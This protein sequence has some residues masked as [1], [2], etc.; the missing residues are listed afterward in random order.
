MLLQCRGLLL[1]IIINKLEPTLPRKVFP[2]CLLGGSCSQPYSLRPRCQLRRPTVMGLIK[3]DFSIFLIYFSFIITKMGMW[4]SEH[5]K[6]RL[7]LCLS[8]SVTYFH[9]EPGIWSICPQGTDVGSDPLRA[10]AMRCVKSVFVRT[11]PSR[12]ALGSGC[13]D[14]SF[15][16]TYYLQAHVDIVDNLEFGICATKVFGFGDKTKF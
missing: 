4:R 7:K 13:E 5:S 3:N 10:G 9:I 11:V 16:K 12:H 8:L 2:W 14:P 6:D 1:L 15:P